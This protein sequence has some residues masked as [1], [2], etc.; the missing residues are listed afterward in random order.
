MKSAP[1]T[2]A[3]VPSSTIRQAA[4]AFCWGSYP[5]LPIVAVLCIPMIMGMDGGDL[6]PALYVV[7]NAFG[8]WL[9]A[10]NGVQAMRKDLTAHVA[11]GTVHMHR[12]AGDISDAKEVK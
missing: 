11:D 8:G 2:P 4:V 5:W 3:A 12:R 6:L 10:R 9:G 1:T 7:T